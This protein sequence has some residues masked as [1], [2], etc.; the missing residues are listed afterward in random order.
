[1]S[2]NLLQAPR[3]GRTATASG[4]D[5]VGRDE[6]PSLAS[7]LSGLL[8]DARTGKVRAT[9]PGDRWLALRIEEALRGFDDIQQMAIGHEPAPP[10]PAGGNAGRVSILASIA[11][12][13]KG[14]V[15]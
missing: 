1:M 2:T 4:P 11:Y 6:V 9:T 8:A 12:E 7:E 14:E 5:A 3:H 10:M 15:K 13:R